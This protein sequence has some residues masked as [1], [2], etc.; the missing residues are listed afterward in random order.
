MSTPACE[1]DDVGK[2][3]AELRAEA[4]RLLNCTCHRP[5]SGGAVDSSGCPVHREPAPVGMLYCGLRDP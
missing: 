2:R 5:D 4:A 3:L 1:S